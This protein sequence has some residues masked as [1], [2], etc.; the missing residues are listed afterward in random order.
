MAEVGVRGGPD[1]A[2]A[3]HGERAAGDPL[4]HADPA[5]RQAGVHPQNTHAPSHGSPDCMFVQAIG[6][7]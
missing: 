7:H 2:D 4:D 5:P 3:E 1:D 6:C